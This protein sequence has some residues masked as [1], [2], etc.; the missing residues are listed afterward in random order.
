[1]D[2][3]TAVV[4]WPSGPKVDRIF[5]AEPTIRTVV[6]ETT[7][8]PTTALTKQSL[9]HIEDGA[10]NDRQDLISMRSVVFLRS[11]SLRSRS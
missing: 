7:I 4:G 8:A 1:M 11:P 6:S 9:Y 2:S 10:I 3:R 5:S